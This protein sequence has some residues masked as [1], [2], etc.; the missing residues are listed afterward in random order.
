MLEKTG[1][2][3]RVLAIPKTNKRKDPGQEENQGKEK[4]KRATRAK[5]TSLR[6]V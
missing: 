1:A 4:A 2:K 3:K 5:N 6:D